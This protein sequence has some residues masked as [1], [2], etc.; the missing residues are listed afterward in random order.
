MKIGTCISKK[1]EKSHGL[2]RVS[3][4]GKSTKLPIYIIEGKERGGTAFISAGM[5][6]DELNG[7]NIVSRSIPLINPKK[8]S[9]TLIFVPTLNPI[10]LHYGERRIRYDALDLNRCFAKDPR[11]FSTKLAKIFF[12]EVVS[13][14]DFG[15]D[16]HDSNKK[17]ILFPH[18]RIFNNE[19][20]AV[21]ELSRFFGTEIVMKRDPSRGM[22]ALEAMRKLKVPVLTIEIGGGMSILPEY[23]EIGLRGINNVLINKGF[24]A[25]DVVLP[26]N[27]FILSERL[28]YRSPLGG[29]L[30]IRKKLGDIVASE[31][32]I[33]D[34]FNPVSGKE[35]TIKARN[36]GILFS[37]KA[38]SHIKANQ[39]ALSLLHLKEERGRLVTPDA[40]V[41]ENREGPGVHTIHTG[42]FNKAFDKVKHGSRKFFEELLNE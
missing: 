27:Q 30:S 14:C 37:V 24:L 39:K 17:N 19:Y 8:V 31:E 41:I 12:D 5:H 33:A 1:G 34:I 3:F 10:G 38:S 7:I 42:V 11:S 36:P 25:G 21:N 22:L 26:H 29:L 32:I 35:G 20:K 40:K 28:G 18:T 23:M 15:L 9:G 16:F 13:Q 6:G 2:L 4:N